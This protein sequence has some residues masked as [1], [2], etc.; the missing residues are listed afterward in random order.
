M[1]GPVS[2]K[3]AE[4]LFEEKRAEKSQRLFGGVKAHPEVFLKRRRASGPSEV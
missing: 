4:G 1:S 2:V 3:K